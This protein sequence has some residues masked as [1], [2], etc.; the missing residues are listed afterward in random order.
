M[1][2]SSQNQ[3]HKRRFHTLGCEHGILIKRLLNKVIF[4]ASFSVVVFFLS[5]LVVVVKDIGKKTCLAPDNKQNFP[6]PTVKS[7]AGANYIQM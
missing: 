7:F 2:L 5:S 1:L 6:R 3:R 4:F